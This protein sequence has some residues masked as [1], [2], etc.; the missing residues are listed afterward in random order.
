MK[1][2]KALLFS[3][4]VILINSCDND[5]NPTNN[6]CDTTYVSSAITNAYSAA[7]GYDDLAEFMDLETHEYSVKINAAGE[8]CSIGYQNPSTYTGGYTMEIINTNTNTSY[9]GVHVFS[10]TGLDYQPITIPVQVNSGDIIIVKRTI[11]PGYTMLNETI[12]RVLRKS[13][14]ANVPYPVIQGNIEF[15]NSNFYGTGGPIPD[16]AQPYIAFGFQ[17]Y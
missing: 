10:Q 4:F 17:V 16:F 11:L 3:F 2:F 9:S 14:N 7:N 6:V 12:G 5:N 8:I 1:T 15:L 13:N